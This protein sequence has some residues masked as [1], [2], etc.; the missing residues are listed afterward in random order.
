MTIQLDATIGAKPRFAAR[1]ALFGSENAFKIAPHIRRVEERG[2]RVI[3]CNV[4]EPDFPLAPHIVAEL[5]HQ[6]DR[7]ETHYVDPQGVEPL[8][9]AVARSVGERRGLHITP[10]RVVVFAGAKPPIGFAQQVYCDPGDEVIYPSPGFPIYESFTR[11]LYLEPVPMHLREEDGFACGAEQIEPLITNR[12]RLIY[13]NFPSNPTGGVASRAQLEEIGRVI[14]DKAP[15]EA[16]VYSDE[17]YEDIL[18]DGARHESIASVPGMEQRTIIVSGVS[19][20]YA[21]TGGRIGWAVFPTAEEA[22]VFRNFNIN[23]FS[24]VCGYNQYAAAYAIEAPESRIA[25]ERMVHK[26]QQRREL[27]VDGLN[28]IPGIRCHKPAGAFYVF[29]NVTGVC[30][31]LG[32]IDAFESLSHVQRMTSSP[33]TL[34][35]L[36]LLFRHGVA[37]LDRRS[38]GTMGNT[39]EHYLRLSI[40]TATDDLVE[41]VRRIGKA[42]TDHRGF[43]DFMREGIVA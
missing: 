39:S 22:A 42:A 7:G 13:L 24:C 3:R 9:V 23:Y 28:A 4:G 1:V 10:D 2:Q 31:E 30:H 14:L 29:P 32:A 25:I 20:S 5:K 8:R 35:Q 17:V 12:T 37:T 19:K 43:A 21:W 18:Y 34:V 6:I 41:A 26:F 38:F 36:F 40:A 33:A 11:F 15:A 27:V 16:R